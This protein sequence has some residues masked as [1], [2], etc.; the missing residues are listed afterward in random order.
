MSRAEH[1]AQRAHDR[2]NDGFN[3]LW[4]VEHASADAARAEERFWNTCSY[5]VGI[6]T[7]VMIAGTIYVLVRL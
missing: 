1:P 5:A 4:A 7:G 6:F 3:E 2:V